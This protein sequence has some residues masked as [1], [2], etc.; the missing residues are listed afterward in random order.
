[1]KKA[2]SV[3]LIA[4]SALLLAVSTPIIHHLITPVALTHGVTYGQAFSKASAATAMNNIAFGVDGSVAVSLNDAGYPDS[5]HIFYANGDDSVSYRTPSSFTG[6]SPLTGAGEGPL[7]AYG[8]WSQDV[9]VFAAHKEE[10]ITE[11]DPSLPARGCHIA[12]NDF[13]SGTMPA[14]DDCKLVTA[15]TYLTLPVMLN[16]GEILITPT[17]YLYEGD[18]GAYGL[19]ITDH[20]DTPLQVFQLPHHGALTG[21]MQYIGNTYED[22]PPIYWDSS[23]NIIYFHEREFQL[24]DGVR[25]SRAVQYSDGFLYALDTKNS[26][27]T[28]WG[29]GLGHGRASSIKFDFFESESSLLYVSGAWLVAIGADEVVVMATDAFEAVPR[30][31]IEIHSFA[32]N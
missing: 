32:L 25:D 4:A 17:S 30:R 28:R 1:M 7:V 24:P 26:T 5:W 15:S 23:D 31:D 21:S 12:W 3:G 14:S 29:I 19:L 22:G 6:L 8:V 18:P 11:L 2:W 13:S 16:P 10:N 9:S 20:P 27:V